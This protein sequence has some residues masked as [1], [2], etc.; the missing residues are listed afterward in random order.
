MFSTGF[1]QYRTTDVWQ[2]YFKIKGGGKFLV[3]VADT[4]AVCIYVK[5][6]TVDT[7]GREA[8]DQ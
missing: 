7:A 1:F 4:V 3:A 5:F 6:A 2:S 8:K